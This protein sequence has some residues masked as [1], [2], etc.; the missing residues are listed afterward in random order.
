MYKH[1]MHEK[2]KQ[3]N[4]QQALPPVS[5]QW[6]SAMFSDHFPVAALTN[7]PCDVTRQSYLAV[8]AREEETK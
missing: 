3:S 7:G 1:H 4:G 5:E 6:R 2:K 8:G